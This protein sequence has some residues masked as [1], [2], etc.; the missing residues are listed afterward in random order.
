MLGTCGNDLRPSTSAWSLQQWYHIVGTYD[1]ASLKVYVDGSLVGTKTTTINTNTDF[2]HVGVGIDTW[3]NG[4]YHY[5][6]NG[7]V[8][9]V[10]LY[11]YAL[12]SSQVGELYGL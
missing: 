4:T 1:G 7:K 3:W 9:E 5:L 8:D 10:K 2:N 12:S 6:C 11:D